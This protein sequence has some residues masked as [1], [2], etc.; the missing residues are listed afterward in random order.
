MAVARAAWSSAAPSCRPWPGA[1]A[2][3]PRS[4]WRAST[5]TRRATSGRPG[6]CARGARAVSAT[7]RGGGPTAAATGRWRPCSDGVG[8]A[9]RPP[10][11]VAQCV[12]IAIVSRHVFCSKFDHV[13]TRNDGCFCCPPNPE[14]ASKSNC[15]RSFHRWDARQFRHR[16][17]FQMIAF[18]PLI[19]AILLF[20]NASRRSWS[21][22]VA[23]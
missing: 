21:R 8:A 10:P 20:F 13:I 3:P 17:H 15:S 9:V 5:R 6:R 2:W 11:S 4:P 7:P 14:R 23:I 1:R 18:G 16:R 12:R 19:L 22:I